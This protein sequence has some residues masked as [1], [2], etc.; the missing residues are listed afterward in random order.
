MLITF[1]V[2]LDVVELKAC[3]EISKCSG[4]V[5]SVLLSISSRVLSSEMW[6]VW[7]KRWKKLCALSKQLTKASSVCCQFIYHVTGNIYFNQCV[8]VSIF[9]SMSL[10][11]FRVWWRNYLFRCVF[12]VYFHGDAVQLKCLLWFCSTYWY[13]YD[14]LTFC[15]FV[16]ISAFCNCKA[17]IAD[18]SHVSVC[19]SFVSAVSACWKS[20]CCKLGLVTFSYYQ[21]CHVC[22]RSSM[23]V[24]C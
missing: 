2:L 24:N 13:F 21:S 20:P 5:T 15:F 16:E 9:V 10:V 4:V 22:G 11:W 23:K 6:N 18:R 12:W 7:N 14:C 19:L 8:E 3:C 17:V 1:I